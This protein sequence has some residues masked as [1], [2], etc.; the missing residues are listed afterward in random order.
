MFCRACRPK[1][2]AGHFAKEAEPLGTRET[3]YSVQSMCGST[4][5]NPWV[6]RRRKAG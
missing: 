6:M 4:P 5:I 1:V 3:T 2:A